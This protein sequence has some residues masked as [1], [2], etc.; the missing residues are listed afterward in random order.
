MVL[1]LLIFNMLLTVQLSCSLQMALLLI[2]ILIVDYIAIKAM[3]EGVDS[4]N[5]TEQNQINAIANPCVWQGGSAVYKA[6]ALNSYWQPSRF[7]DDRYLCTN[8]NKNGSA[9]GF[10]SMVADST[11]LNQINN[12][13]KTME[14]VQDETNTISIT[15]NPASTTLNVYYNKTNNGELNLYNNLGEIVLK[16]ALSEGNKIVSIDISNLPNGIYSC[17]TMFIGEQ[18]KVLKIEIK[19]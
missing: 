6:R 5:Q 15:P 7:Y 17:K 10:G 3:K 16:T 4:I 12:A 19:H 13:P 8:S 2:I 9:G 18:V 11:I 14:I 1:I